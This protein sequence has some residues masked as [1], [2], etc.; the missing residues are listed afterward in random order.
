MKRSELEKRLRDA[1]C[2]LSRNGSKHDKW[3]NPKTGK[4]DWIPRHAKEVP[5]GTALSILKNLS[6]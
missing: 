4:S 3:K 1:G 6:A 5:T 2:V